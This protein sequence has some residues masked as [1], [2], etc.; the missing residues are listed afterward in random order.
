MTE[1][2][3]LGLGLFDSVFGLRLIMPRVTREQS[4]VSDVLA[5]PFD[6][7]TAAASYRTERKGSLVCISN[8][9]LLMTN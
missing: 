6:L 4:P 9:V 1:L 5:L 7:Y 8:M 2:F 3:G